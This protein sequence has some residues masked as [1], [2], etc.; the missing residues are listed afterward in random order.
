MNEIKFRHIY[1]IREKKGIRKKKK[2]NFCEAKN[3]IYYTK[4]ERWNFWN[5][6]QQNASYIYMI[7]KICYLIDWDSSWEQ[8]RKYFIYHKKHFV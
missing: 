1:K 4:I 2:I 8:C 7:K 5:S 6:T 3:L